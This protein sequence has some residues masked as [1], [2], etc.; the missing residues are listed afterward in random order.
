MKNQG[1]NMSI[2]ILFTAIAMIC[3]G[4]LV[5]KNIRS[6]DKTEISQDVRLEA[7]EN[8]VINMAGKLEFFAETARKQENLMVNMAEHLKTM[9]ARPGGNY[10][11]EFDEIQRYL[12]ELRKQ[13]QSF[14]SQLNARINDVAKSMPKMIELSLKKIQS[15]V[16]ISISREPKNFKTYIKKK[17]RRTNNGHEIIEI[18][19]E[20]PTIPGKPLP[21]LKESKASLVSHDL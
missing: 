20:V 3:V 10:D 4:Y 21:G 18:R 12:A 11:E 13:Q 6:G 7:V 19:K 14:N 2:E 15:P 9:A 8:E 16:P 1:G 17:I 5:F